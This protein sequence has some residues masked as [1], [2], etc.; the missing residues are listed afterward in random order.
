VFRAAKEYAYAAD[1]PGK[2][3]RRTGEEK[4]KRPVEAGIN[5]NRRR[6]R[7]VRARARAGDTP[8]IKTG[9]LTTTT[10]AAGGSVPV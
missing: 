9:A 1:A 3:V 5:Q 8:E 6:R 7:R 4:I 10:A 2:G